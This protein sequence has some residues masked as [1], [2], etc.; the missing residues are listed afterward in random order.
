MSSCDSDYYF[1]DADYSSDSEEEQEELEVEVIQ[2]GAKYEILHENALI[3]CMSA[4]VE[5]LTHLISLPP[6][7]IRILLNRFNGMKKN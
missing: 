6:N 7:S 1:S 5:R 4:S 2:E 3:E